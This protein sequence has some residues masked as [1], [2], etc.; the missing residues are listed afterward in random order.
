MRTTLLVIGI[1]LGVLLVWWIFRSELAGPAGQP[2][3]DIPAPVEPAP[4]DP[5]DPGEE[6]EVLLGGED[7]LSFNPDDL[8]VRADA[9][10]FLVTDGSSRMM[11]FD[12]REMASRAVRIIRHYEMDSQCFAIRPDAALRYFKTG[13]DIPSGSFQDED[14]IR[15]SDP[16]GLTIRESSSELFQVLDGNSIP[17]AATSREEAERVI[18]IIRHYQAGFTCYVERPDPGMV[19]LRR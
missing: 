11:L 12:T 6:A 14:C 2:V 8:E 3:T 9:G 16:A 5:A 7:C 10:R 15:I 1:I 4:E 17:Y 19:Y 18:E 13:E